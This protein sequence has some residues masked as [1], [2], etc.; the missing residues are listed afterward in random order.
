MT[1]QYQKQLQ[2]IINLSGSRGSTLKQIGK[3]PKGLSKHI[4]INDVLPN[5]NNFVITD[6]ADGN[7]GII[8]IYNE[9]AHIL[10]NKYWELKIPNKIT[11]CIVE[12]EILE[13]HK[14]ILIYDILQWENNTVINK[15]FKDRLEYINKLSLELSKE[16]IEGWLIQS[17]KFTELS[18]SSYQNNILKLYNE[19]KKY[20]YETDGIIFTDITSDYQKAK[21]YKWKPPEKL[22]IDFLML[23]DNADKSHKLFSGIDRRMF[24][25]Y[26]LN[27]CL[28]Y[29]ELTSKYNKFQGDILYSDFFP[30]PFQ[31][32]IDPNIYKINYPLEFDKSFKKNNKF[33]DFNGKIVEMQYKLN[34]DKNQQNNGGTKGKWVVYR[35]RTDREYELQSGTYYGNNFYVAEQLFHEIIHPFTIKD[36]L[37]PYSKLIKDVY[38]SKKDNKYADVRKYNNR[39]KKQLISRY[40]NSQYVID[41]GSGKGQD[42]QKYTDAKIGNLMML[43]V[44]KS[45][46]DELI[47]TMKPGILNKAW[48]DGIDRPPNIATYKPQFQL[49]VSQIN[50]IEPTKKNIEQLSLKFLQ[51]KK[52]AVD[53]LFCN[54]AFHYLIETPKNLSNIIEFITYWLKPKG[55]FIFT[56]FSADSINN[57]LKSKNEWVIK[58]KTRHDSTSHDSTSLKSHVKSD[59]ILYSIKKKGNIIDVLIPCSDVPKKESLINLAKLDIEFKKAGIMRIETDKFSKYFTDSEI[60]H[61][62][63]LSPDDKQFISLYSYY[64]WQKR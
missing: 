62:L 49:S 44:D 22:T 6:K 9:T 25:K 63:D 7:R 36:L 19:I 51:F 47:F 17:K 52:N 27:F 37:Q 20:P 10:T 50:L 4:Y 15:N 55:F 32:S 23:Y 21:H 24:K 2:K 45:A 40:S 35:I 42:L 18:M 5:I 1:D 56:A 60:T 34:N 14:L 30:I 61:E 29:K 64:I 12:C 11:D 3:S 53:V 43:E 59:D 41:M 33:S 48:V 31:P 28:N 39:V 46:I 16:K 54:L 58:D 57:L 13:E 8:D 26:G 38:F